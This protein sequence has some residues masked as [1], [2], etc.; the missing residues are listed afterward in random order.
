MP[1]RK[2]QCRR[3]HRAQCC[4]SRCNCKHRSLPLER[5]RLWAHKSDD[6]MRLEQLSPPT[7]NQHHLD[8]LLKTRHNY[9][10]REWQPVARL[11]S[12][13]VSLP[14]KL[15][16]VG[17]DGRSWVCIDVTSHSALISNRLTNIVVSQKLGSVWKDFFSTLQVTM[18]L[19]V[20]ICTS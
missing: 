9:V 13:V 18:E 1:N 4:F 5:W 17:F 6:R 14:V 15:V 7:C 10:T 11:H 12:F 3:D 16:G 20:I 19:H 2:V 8:N